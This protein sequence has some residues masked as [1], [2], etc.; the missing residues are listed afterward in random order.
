MQRLFFL[1][2]FFLPDHSAT[3]QLVGDLATHLAASGREVHVITSRQLYNDP[4]ARLP[5]REIISGVHVHRVPSAQF[6]RSNLVGR[7]LDYFSFYA[8]AWSACLALVRREDLIIAMT[9]PPLVSVV[10]MRVARRREALL[11]N[12]LQDIYPEVAVELGVPF[13]KGPITRGLARLR[14][15]CLKVA[16]VNVVVGEL[17]AEQVASRNVSAGRI[18]V[19]ANWSDDDVIHPVAPNDNYLR[20]KWE[21]QD[22]FVVGYSG[23]LGRAH[24]Y[25]TILAAAERLKS[26]PSIVFVF[27]GGGHHME[28]LVRSVKV[29]GLGSFRFFSY[30]DRTILNF[31]LSVPDV[32]WISLRPTL[33]GLIVPSKLYGIAAVGRP[34]IAITAKTGEIARLV[35]QYRC[36]LVIEPGSADELAEALLRLSTDSEACDRMGRNARAMLD[37]RFS[38]RHAFECWRAVI[39]TFDH[40]D[41]GK[42]K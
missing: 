9:D 29:K 40:R 1:N 18:N 17:M 35:R 20:R 23:N 19:I 33:E 27:I 16:V 30:R 26:N 39:S 2:R 10:A 42:L 5:A 8:S 41:G 7:G 14:D 22:K 32:H 36:G 38:R 21:L 28:A 13:L 15:R 25:E 34:I 37:S 4:T 31:S 3:S 11:I 24:E 6:G 12:W